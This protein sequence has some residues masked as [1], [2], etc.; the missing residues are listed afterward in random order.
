VFFESGAIEPS[1][2][3]RGNANDEDG[4]RFEP[5]HVEITSA[6]QVQIYE[7]IMRDVDGNVTTGLLRATGYLK[8]N[9]LLPRGFDKASAAADIAVI[10]AA[11][12]DKDFTAASDRIRYVVG[13]AGRNGPFRID[14]EL[15]YQP[16]SYR[17]AHNLRPYD[18]VE[19][20]RFFGWYEAMSSG[21]SELIASTTVQHP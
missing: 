13:T 7:S 10:G 9:R 17:W 8:D 3:I 18:A 21:S 15:R 2:L 6:D 14:V 19:T 11:R 5:H 4:S 12:E 16:I 20:K 1:G